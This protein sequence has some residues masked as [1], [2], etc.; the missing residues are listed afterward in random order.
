MVP[1]KSSQHLDFNDWLR[2]CPAQWIKKS[3]DD[4]VAT[5]EF[6][7]DDVEEDDEDDN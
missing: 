7:F 1:D 3:Y 5:Y 6:I 2:Q 4:E